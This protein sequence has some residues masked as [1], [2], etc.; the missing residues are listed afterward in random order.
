MVSE[1]SLFVNRD[2]QFQSVVSEN[3]H[4]GRTRDFIYR[5]VATNT[6]FQNTRDFIG[7][8]VSEEFQFLGVCDI[9]KHVVL[10]SARFQS[11]LLLSDVCVS[12]VVFAVVCVG[13]QFS[14][15]Q[16]DR[17]QW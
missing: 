1:S 5:V 17:Y 3:S 10:S 4:L 16:V 12:G 8:M 9:N 7:R 2:T 14:I 13:N 6:W 15:D 11:D